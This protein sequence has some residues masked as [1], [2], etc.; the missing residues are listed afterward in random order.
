MV[1][2]AQL[3][4]LTQPVIDLSHFVLAM[5][6]RSFC[7]N[8]KSPQQSESHTNVRLVLQVTGHLVF[9]KTGLCKVNDLASWQRAQTTVHGDIPGQVVLGCVRKQ[10]EHAIGSKFMNIVPPRPLTQFL[11]RGSCLD[12][13]PDFDRQC[14]VNLKLK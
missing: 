12:A 10:T 9:T 6:S 11:P 4:H 7:D 1:C 2:V 14:T 5:C 8:W 13:W 3:E